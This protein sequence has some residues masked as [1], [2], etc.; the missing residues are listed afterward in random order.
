MGASYSE[1]VPYPNENIGYVAVVF[2][3]HDKVRV[4]NAPLGAVEA[5]K[6]VIT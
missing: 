6:K 1:P 5:I 2:R 4:I 3:T